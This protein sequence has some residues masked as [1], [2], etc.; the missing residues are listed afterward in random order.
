MFGLGIAE[1]LVVLV[2]ALLVLGPEKLPEAARQ[3][4][5][6]TAE[7]RRAMEDIR[8]DVSFQDR[9][10][11]DIGRL[12]SELNL[13]GSCEDSLET[14]PSAETKDQALEDTTDDSK[15]P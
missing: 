9:K 14:K 12:T 15:K 7:L 5:R 3:L 1:I 8:H 2:L 10:Q 11:F 4:G 6:L 13:K